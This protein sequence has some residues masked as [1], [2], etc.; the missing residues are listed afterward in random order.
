MGL[1]KES[2]VDTEEMEESVEAEVADVADMQLS[3]D[4]DRGG[5]W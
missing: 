5:C 2:A 3:V 4:A 1:L